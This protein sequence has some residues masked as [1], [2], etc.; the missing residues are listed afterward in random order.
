MENHSGDLVSRRARQSGDAAYHPYQ[1]VFR[2]PCD[3][4]EERA[5]GVCPRRIQLSAGVS[6]P[7]GRGRRRAA[8][9]RSLPYAGG[10]IPLLH[11]H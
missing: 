8:G 7:N 2:Q 4:L 9:G 11:L 5:G 10:R 3:F 6:L 1:R